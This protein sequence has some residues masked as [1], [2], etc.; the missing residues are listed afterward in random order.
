VCVGVG[1]YGALM[2]VARRLPVLG[3]VN[4]GKGAT[5][6]AMGSELDRVRA[7]VWARFSGAKTAHLSK[8]QIR[9]RLMAEHAPDK[10]AV[11]QR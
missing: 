8:R 10:F 2:K 1:G 4:P 11:P 5:L 9:D 3:T 7:E 6:T